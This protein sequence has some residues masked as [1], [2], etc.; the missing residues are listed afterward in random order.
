MVCIAYKGI[1]IIGVIHYPFPRENPQTYWGW[2]AKKT[3]SNVANV[4]HVRFY[5]LQY[6]IPCNKVLFLM[7]FFFQDCSF[8]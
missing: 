3:S 1:P 4:V 8:C 5:L 6:S 2:L 7:F